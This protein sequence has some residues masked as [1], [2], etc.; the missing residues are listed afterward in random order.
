[1]EPPT[2]K[3]LMEVIENM[4]TVM[5]ELNEIAK[6]HGIQLALEIIYLDE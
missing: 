5:D 4:Q 1:M 3:E 2:R 6:E